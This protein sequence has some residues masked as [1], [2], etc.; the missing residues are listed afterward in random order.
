[1]AYAFLP[2]RLRVYS[3]GSVFSGEKFIKL[4]ARSL[5]NTTHTLLIACYL[6]Y[7]CFVFMTGFLPATVLFARPPFNCIEARLIALLNL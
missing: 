1:M 6:Q 3:T 5:T 2:S 4:C 7:M